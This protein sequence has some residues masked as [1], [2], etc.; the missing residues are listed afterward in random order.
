MAHVLVVVE[1]DPVDLRLW[2]YGA[3][4]ATGELTGD[5][6]RLRHDRATRCG[7]P[8]DPP[9]PHY[10]TAVLLVRAAGDRQRAVWDV[11]AAAFAEG[12]GRPPEPPQS[13][14][15]GRWRRST[16]GKAK[17]SG[18]TLRQRAERPRPGPAAGSHTEP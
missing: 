10:P 13:P 7:T 6:R 16:A 4:D 9:G 17:G 15:D 1:R 11:T 5:A 3:A 18:V 8:L 12:P 2:R 14:G